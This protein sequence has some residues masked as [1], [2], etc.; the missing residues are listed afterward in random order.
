MPFFENWKWIWLGVGVGLGRS[1]RQEHWG[2]A[3]MT[4]GFWV[5]WTHREGPWDGQS[6]EIL[7]NRRPEG[8]ATP[9]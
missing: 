9:W 3:R 5:H 7:E 6:T 8:N 1:Q 4:P 2:T